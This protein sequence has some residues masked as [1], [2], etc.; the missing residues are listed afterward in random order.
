MKIGD[1]ATLRRVYEE[2]ADRKNRPDLPA[3]MIGAM[4]STLLGTQLPGP[5]TRYLKQSLT[6]S[7][8][9]GYGEVLQATVTLTRL[10]PEKRL[11]DL[12]TTCCGED[13]RVLCSGRALVKYP[14]PLEAKDQTS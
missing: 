5:G 3:I 9:P 1:T 11:A 10:R 2:T 13:G 8:H 12:T 4:F 7:A 6:F 14:Q